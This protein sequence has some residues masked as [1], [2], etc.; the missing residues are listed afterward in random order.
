MKK[1]LEKFSQKTFKLQKT[2]DKKQIDVEIKIQIC[3]IFKLILQMREDYL[4]NNVVAFFKQEFVTA[5]KDGD[6]L[7]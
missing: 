6:D 4:L 2:D 7:L 3:H 5:G 1:I